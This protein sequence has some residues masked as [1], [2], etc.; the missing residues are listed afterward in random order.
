[1][2]RI[3]HTRYDRGNSISPNINSADVTIA[4]EA[5]SYFGSALSAGD[6]NSDSKTDLAVG[7]YNYST[8]GAVYLFYN[9]GT[10]NLGTTTCTGSPALCYASNSDVKLTGDMSSYFGSSM[11]AGDFNA[12]GRIDLAV[13]GYNYSG[14]TGRVY[15]FNNDGTYGTA[16]TKIDGETGSQFG[17]SMTSGDFDADGK[18]DL[19][20]GGYTY[21]T[22]AGRAYIFNGDAAIPTS[23]SAADTKID[24]D[25]SSQFGYSVIS[26]DFNADGKTDLAVGA[27]AHAANIG[28]AYVFY[29]DGTIPSTASSADISIGGESI[30]FFGNSMIAGDFNSDGKTDLAIGAPAYLS[31]LGRTYIF[32]AKKNEVG[33]VKIDMDNY[34]KIDGMTAAGNFGSVLAAGD[35]SGD[36]ITDLVV[37]AASGTSVIGTVSVY[38]M[39]AGPIFKSPV[40]VRGA[41]KTRGSVK[42]Y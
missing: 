23:A 27:R 10:V 31:N 19:A 36:G 39:E 7:A 8:T 24:G 29:N 22:N 25:A 37:S 42:V 26:G 32:Y 40:V 11:T 4:G 41:F 13:G 38:P 30:S 5:G 1:M 2:F 17:F 28:R 33:S 12:D 16:D 18:T 20:V 35:F 21:S 14:S 15:I 6:F 9:D 3:Y 34:A